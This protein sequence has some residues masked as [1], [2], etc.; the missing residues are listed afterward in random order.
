[1]IWKCD[2]ILLVGFEV[3]KLSSS[4]L[5]ETSVMSTASNFVGSLLDN[6]KSKCR[7]VHTENLIHKTF[8]VR[9]LIF[10]NMSA[11]YID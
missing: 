7:L 3:L 5:E 10:L 9:T 8:P 2:K 11:S 1:M 6:F 4:E